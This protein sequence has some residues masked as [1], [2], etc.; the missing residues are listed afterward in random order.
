MSKKWPL[1]TLL[2]I[3]F[4][5]TPNPVVAASC[6]TTATGEPCHFTNA[7]DFEGYTYDHVSFDPPDE[8]TPEDIVNKF[9]NISSLLIQGGGA[10]IR[11][12]SD[13]RTN[14][15]GEGREG[16]A[17]SGEWRIDWGYF[18]RSTVFISFTEP[19]DAV[20]VFIGGDSNAWNRFSTI[21]AVLENGETFTTNRGEAGLLG[22]RE[23]A[24]G[25][26]AINGFL[27]IDSNSG[28]KISHVTLTHNNDAASLD[29]IFFGIAAGGSNGPGPS[30][31]P[32]S[33]FNN[34]ADCPLTYAQLPSGNTPPDPS[35]NQPPIAVAGTS[36]DL[37]ESLQLDGSLSSD[38]DSDPLTFSWQIEGELS[39]RVGQTVLISDLM[40]GTYTVALTV[41][42]GQD[43]NTD[44]MLL[45]I[46]EA[47]PQQQAEDTVATVS[48][49][50]LTSFSGNNANAQDAKQTNFLNKL[51]NVL[52]AIAIGDY[53][54]AID[55]LRVLYGKTDNS[56]NDDWVTGPEA[57]QLAD[58]ISAL[59]QN[60]LSNCY[61][62]S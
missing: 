33:P 5:Y 10:A 50:P 38:P 60:L 47:D 43:S 26:N 27:G 37:N 22:V 34:S 46:T 24:T 59:I 62:C 18:S 41:S 20:G 21:E 30:P 48:N 9:S 7:F 35:T 29:S 58:D 45:G 44:V 15:S 49:I 1:L 28:P 16:G 23:N 3:P 11:H 17:V 51:D 4:I 40:L 13:H 14:F 19:V 25:C 42:D 12:T 61:S 52:Q 6:E 54:Q 55:D 8:R 31:L 57:Q 36:L 39:P 56:G 32:E 2:L 53:Q